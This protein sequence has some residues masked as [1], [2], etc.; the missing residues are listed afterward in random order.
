MIRA[1]SGR[2]RVLVVDDVEANRELLSQDLED[3]GFE[4]AIVGSGPACLEAVDRDP[5]EVILLDI[6]MSGMD[7]IETC[8][9]LKADPNTAH[10]PVLF[11][12]AARGNEQTAVAA[13]QAGG[14]DFLTKPYSPPILIARV[15]CQVTI[16]RA[17]ARLRELATTDEL[18]GVSSRRHVFDSLRQT[19]KLTSRTPGCVACLLADVDHFKTINDTYGHLEGDRVLRTVA[20]TIQSCVRE[21]DVVGRYGGEE[22][23]VLLPHTGIEGARTVGEKIRGAVAAVCAPITISIGAAARCAA[24]VPE[25]L[26]EAG[27]EGLVTGLI[28]EADLA[29]YAAKAAGRNRVMCAPGAPGALADR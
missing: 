3:E 12:T 29:T 6:Q 9:R 17:H 10:I 21:T 13:L 27:M 19:I 2:G 24:E 15:S 25:M 1:T 7:G 16:S 14:N 22:F 20:H 28:K 26:D 4:V 11:V 23:V 5:P 8:R 18:T